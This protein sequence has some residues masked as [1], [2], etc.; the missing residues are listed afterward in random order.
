MAFNNSKK[1]IFLY[2]EKTEF[3]W[4]GSIRSLWLKFRIN[5]N[6]RVK[7]LLYFDLQPLRETI[8][9]TITSFLARSCNFSC[10]NYST[11]RKKVCNSLLQEKLQLAGIIFRAAQEKN[12][13][14][15]GQW[16]F[17][18]IVQRRPRWRP[19]R[20]KIW[21][22]KLNCCAFS[23]VYFGAFILTFCSH[24]QGRFWVDWRFSWSIYIRISRAW[25]CVEYETQRQQK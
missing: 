10:K 20:A 1:T 23:L 5:G 19:I 17:G 8:G 15:C 7:A 21:C 25:M 4:D 2:K 18:F 9:K 11:I 16:E 13:Q 22:C 6:L 3:F 14:A 24:V 12:L